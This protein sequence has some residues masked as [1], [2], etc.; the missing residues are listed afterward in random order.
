[1]ISKDSEG[2]TTTVAVV[3]PTAVG[4]TVVSIAVA[5]RLGAE[6][7]SAD[8]RQIY[9]GMDIGTAKPTPAEQSLVRHHLIDIVE[10]SEVYDAARFASDA[11]SVITDLLEDG[12]VPIVVG[13][14]GF[15]LESLF[16]GLFEGPGRDDRIREELKRRM[17][18]TGPAA[19]HAELAEADP[20][21]ASRIHPNDGARIVRALEVSLSSGVPLS[22]WQAGPAREPAYDP[23]YFGLTMSRASLYSRI[24]ERVDR[25]MDAGLLDETRALVSSGRLEPNAPAASAVG[26]RELLPLATGESDDVESAVAAI[27]RNTRRYAKRQLTWFSSFADVTWLD[28]EALG[29]ESAADRISAFCEAES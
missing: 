20:E 29:T 22:R 12:V 5:L 27:K 14:T 2:R 16:T 7:V 25:M 21:A 1:M 6:I 4:K 26:Y 9:R 17:E 19:L 10:P 13:G 3:G 24:D 18:R 15:Y 23:R 28:V 8:S 11:E